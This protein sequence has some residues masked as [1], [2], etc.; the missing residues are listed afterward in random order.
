[1]RVEIEDL[2]K[3]LVQLKA[4][5]TSKHE[6]MKASEFRSLRSSRRELSGGLRRTPRGRY[7]RQ[8]AAI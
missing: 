6:E 2:E 7:F 5:F 8:L 1:M 4:E 3:Q